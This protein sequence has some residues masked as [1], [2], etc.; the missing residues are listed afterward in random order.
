MYFVYA[1]ARVLE[2][3]GIKREVILKKNLLVVEW[4]FWR[5]FG[6]CATIFR[7]HGSYSVLELMLV[8]VVVHSEK[9][10][11]QKYP[12]FKIVF[13]KNNEYFSKCMLQ[14]TKRRVEL[15]EMHCFTMFITAM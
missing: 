1:Y 10:L 11:F 12:L 15:F 8:Q 2:N 4:P 5:I 14:Q 3:T 6:K 13:Q 7:G 9:I